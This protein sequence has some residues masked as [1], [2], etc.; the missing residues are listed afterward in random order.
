MRSV[1]ISGGDGFLGRALADHFTG[2][3]VPVLVI[4][5][6]STSRPRP[7][8]P[9]RRTIVADVCDVGMERLPAVS[10]VLH[11]ASPAAPT[12]FSDRPL[13]TI[14]P[15]TFGT[16]AMLRVARRDA[17]RLVFASTSEAYGRGD[18]AGPTD[19]AFSERQMVSHRLLTSRS[20]YAAAK[21]L[22]EELVLAAREEG[23]DA[24]AIRP[25]NVYG[26]GM[27]PTLPGYGRVVPNFLRAVRRG[28]PLPIH[29]DGRQVRSFLWIGDFVRAVVALLAAPEV[30]PA[31]NVGCDEPVS[32][33]ALAE[34][35]ERCAGRPPCRE[36]L[37]RPDDDPDW[38]R[39]DCSLLASLT[40]WA[41]RVS[42]EEG[43]RRLLDSERTRASHG[44]PVPTHAE[45]APCR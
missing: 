32:I 10:A 21:R 24:M 29:G 6:H 39:P 2:Q 37:A 34:V 1:L 5:D 14:R 15:N 20:R 36:R 31:V 12:L 42:L 41:P 45:V 3:G 27:D 23:A 26:P 38:R 17:C 8:H 28:E 7:E 22:G 11:L 4:D 16:D 30:P 43:V 44:A 18:P 25:F 13:A 40:G 35:V 33:A 9:L 19:Q